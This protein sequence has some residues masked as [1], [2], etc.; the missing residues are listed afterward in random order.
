MNILISFL[1][2][3]QSKEADNTTMKKFIYL[4][5]FLILIAG[6]LSAQDRNVLWAHGLGDNA[7]FWREQADNAQ[8][9]YRIRSSR[10]THPT[11]EGV[12]GYANRL[13]NSS[14]LIRGNPNDRGWA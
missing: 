5:F 13:R 7:E 3:T 4:S 6:S 8:N 10:F 9:T 14:N 2:T 11:N 12:R 1:K